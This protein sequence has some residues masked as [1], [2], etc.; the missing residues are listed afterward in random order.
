M[1][2]TA[3]GE[4]AGPVAAPEPPSVEV[5]PVVRRRGREQ[6]Q[7][8]DRQRR[9]RA[10]VWMAVFSVASVALMSAL[11][12]VGYRASLKI[13]G[14]TSTVTDPEAPGYVA[15]V[16]P[17]PVDL[18]ALTT[19]D[20]ELAGVVVV[21]AGN[22]GKGGAVVPLP[23]ELVIPATE[24]SGD[25]SLAVAFAAGGLE[26]LRR[27][28]GAA[29]GFGFTSASELSAAEFEQLVGLVGPITVENLD[30]LVP[31]RNRLTEGDTA[32]EGLDEVRY[33]SGS[34]TL[35][36]DE[37]VEYLA[38]RGDGEPVANQ[39]LRHQAVWRAVLD[40][41]AGRD[42]DELEIAGSGAEFVG[43]LPDLLAGPVL[44]ETLPIVERGVPGTLFKVSVP[45]PAQ[46]P[47]F[48]AR[49]IPA[50]TAAFPGQRARVRILNGTTDRN[51]TALVAP[52]VVASGGLIASVGNAASFDEPATRVVHMAPEARATAEAIAAAL[53]VTATAATTSDAGVD[54]EVVIGRDRA[55]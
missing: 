37:V 35:Q 43:L 33:P 52:K 4:P 44:H 30:N 11:A 18:V 7:R 34:L 54:V 22:G 46:L 28:L 2:T 14:G 40:G 8:R 29:V 5:A 3:P 13:T 1:T 38:F 23:A 55:P 49:L 12:L 31:A 53:G 9:R 27:R 39:A 36:P 26:E 20:G 45:D 32:P 41:L 16:Q 6:R 48:T 21:T 25:D 19:D 42:A 10:T 24:G 51:A 50:P 47:G 15:E 17:T